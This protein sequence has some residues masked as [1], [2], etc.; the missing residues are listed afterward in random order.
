MRDETI[1][2]LIFIVLFISGTSISIYYRRRAQKASKDEITYREEGLFVMYALRLLGLGLWVAVIA[3][4]TNPSWMRW[5]SISLPVWFRWGA[6]GLAGIAWG[7]ILWMLRSLGKNI[8]STV[9]TRK[10]HSLVMNGP[11][12]WIRHPL[13]TFATLF[14]ISLGLM[15]ANWFI[16]LMTLVVFVLL[17]VRTP[18]EEEKLIE[19]FGED[20]QRYMQRTGRF[21]PRLA[22]GS[23]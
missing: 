23:R 6:V 2:R 18:K 17:A 1:F 7:L 4:M 11:Y 10:E 13:Y 14:Y 15:A 9:V 19:K 16:P 21:L 3:Y 20:Y 5:A 12:R 22:E 8:T